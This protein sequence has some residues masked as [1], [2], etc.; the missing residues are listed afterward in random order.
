MASL[1]RQQRALI[2]MRPAC[3]K[4]IWIIIV[5]GQASLPLA[6]GEAK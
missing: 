6:E 2:P 1:T 3:E 4:L 5:F